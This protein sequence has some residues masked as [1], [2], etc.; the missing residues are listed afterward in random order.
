MVQLNKVKPFKN[1]GPGEHLQEMMELRDWTQQDLGDVLGVSTKHVNKL[2]KNEQPITLNMAKL[3][4]EAFNLSPEFWVNIDTKYRLRL[5]EGS[6]E[7]KDVD[8]RS[9]VYQYMPINEMT[10]KGWFEKPE[11]T[12]ELEQLV[13]D[14][15][16]LKS[17][18]HEVLAKP[19]ELA[20]RKSE[21]F[22]KFNAYAAKC[23]FQMAKNSSENQNTPNYDK[24]KLKTLAKKLHTFTKVE[25]GVS[26]VIEKLNEAGVKFLVLSHL[27]KTYIDGASFI[28][29]G[30]PVIVYTA[31]YKRNDNF[32]FTLAHEIAHV[33]EHLKDEGK[34]ILDNFLDKDESDIE[35][36]AN[37]L[38]A[39]YLKHVEILEFFDND[40]SYI[41]QEQIEECSEKHEVHTAIIMGALAFKKVISYKYMHKFTEDVRSKIPMD[42][43]ADPIT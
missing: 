29:N 28:Y 10:R 43:Y 26:K 2:L 21:A 16:K 35:R 8:M 11:N 40:L 24:A 1:I 22:E 25:N 20:Y 31:R 42:F 37:E 33:L 38:A 30:N 12:D 14:F 5:E 36:E 18:D 13:C 4:G 15:W 23:W 9:K 39:Q 3:L 34:P 32:W 41:T 27:Q 7:E 17:F 6:E 19:L